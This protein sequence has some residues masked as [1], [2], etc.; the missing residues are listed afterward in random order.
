[1][2]EGGCRAKE[3]AASEVSE[4]ELREWEEEQKAGEPGTGEGS[5]LFLPMPDFMASA[6][7]GGGRPRVHFLCPSRSLSF[8]LLFSRCDKDKGSSDGCQRGILCV[9]SV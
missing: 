7:A 6:G 9:S 3:D 1:M 5:L 8:L 4:A 2:W